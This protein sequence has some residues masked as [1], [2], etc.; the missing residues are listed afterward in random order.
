MGDGLTDLDREVPPTV[1]ITIILGREDPR[2]EQL[3]E[4]LRSLRIAY[5]VKR[6]G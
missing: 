2:L 5:L 6:H 4:T 3:L 1:E